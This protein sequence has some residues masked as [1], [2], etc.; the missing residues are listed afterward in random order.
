MVVYVKYDNKKP[1]L[2]VAVADSK[3]ELAQKLGVSLHNVL[4]SFYHG[5]ST[6]AEVDI[7]PIENVIPCWPDNDGG[8]WYKDPE[9]GDTVYLRD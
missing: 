3:K 6:Y 5:R 1:N 9:T 8:L 7:G 4:S 2:P